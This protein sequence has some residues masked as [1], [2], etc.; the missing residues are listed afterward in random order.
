MKYCAFVI[1]SVLL[2]CSAGCG[3]KRPAGMPELYPCTITLT[4][5]DKPATGVSI[6]L[7]S[8]GAPCEWMVGAQTDANGVAAIMTYGQYNGAPEG[9]FAV[10][11]DKTVTEGVDQNA[12]VQKKPVK[13]YTMVDPK[14]KNAE[15]SPLEIKIEGKKTDQ[16][17]E[18]GP[19]VKKLIETIQ[20]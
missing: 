14:Y 10:V 16:K 12:D 15:T 20:P 17:F 2:I 3:P 8:K 1:F 4:E 13:I 7:V 9:T 18:L 5:G 11:L 19:P 6:Q